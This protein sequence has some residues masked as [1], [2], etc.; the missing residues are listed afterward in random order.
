MSKNEAQ[1]FSSFFSPFWG[2]NFLVGP[3]RK[4]LGPTI[5][6]P[7]FPLNQTHSKDIF[8]SF[9]LQSFPSTLFYLQTQPK[10]ITLILIFYSN[11]FLSHLLSI[12]AFSV[13]LYLS[14][15]PLFLPLLYHT[16]SD[17]T[18]HWASR[19]TLE[20]SSEIQVDLSL[21]R[22]ETRADLSVMMLLDSV[23]MNNT[24]NRSDR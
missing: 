10:R 14:H 24:V 2:K 7:S 3:G 17:T 21:T 12:I 23:M 6:F 9:S 15:F 8:F 5:Y 16:F 18:W 1:F 22:A 13:F 20:L 11:F 19:T 4:Y